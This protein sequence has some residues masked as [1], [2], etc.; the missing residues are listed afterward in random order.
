M[1]L[2]VS[3]SMLKTYSLCPKKYKLRYVEGIRQ[4]PTV[5][6]LLGRA[7]HKGIE[8]LL[9][10]MASIGICEEGIGYQAFEDY[11]LKEA[12]EKGVYVLPHE[13]ERL[14][15]IKK[16]DITPEWLEERFRDTGKEV[17]GMIEGELKRRFGK[18]IEE[19]SDIEKEVRFSF[20]E[21]AEVL[22]DDFWRMIPKGERRDVEKLLSCVEAEGRIDLCLSKSEKEVI[23]F[24]V[25]R[26][27]RNYDVSSDEQLS[28][29][30]LSLLLK[31]PDIREVKTSFFLIKKDIWDIFKETKA[32][33]IKG[34]RR[35]EDIIRYLT[36]YVIPLVRGIRD[37]KFH[38]TDKDWMCRYCFYRWEG[39][40]KGK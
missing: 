24:K 9:K 14:K 18:E 7:I 22:K 37:G 23:D 35:R 28:F 1:Y 3:P 10:E 27:I 30:A 32:L 6:F 15:E 12:R 11:F 16:I 2:I 19:V 33:Y 39:Y 25:G 8:I 20:S 34:K 36:E 21:I 4:V 26:T 31:E 40:C 17:F 29:Y 13:K 38:K 5:S